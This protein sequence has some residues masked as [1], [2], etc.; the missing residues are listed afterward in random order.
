MDANKLQVLRALDFKEIR[1]CGNCAAGNF[2]GNAL[3]GTCKLHK[4]NHLKHSDSDRELSI[5]RYGVCKY[6]SMTI[7]TAESTKFFNYI[8]E[9]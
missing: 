8:K 1:C 2:T 5:Y 9:K 3:F 6:P 4:Y 7:I